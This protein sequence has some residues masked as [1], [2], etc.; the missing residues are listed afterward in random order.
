M[1]KILNSN[2][3]QNKVCLVIGTRPGIVMFSPIIRALKKIKFNFFI[4]HAGQH[5]S[6]NMDKKF[7]EDLELPE[8]EY[9]LDEVKNCKF[10]GEQ[11]ARMLEGI[12]KILLKE[13]PKIV[14]VGGDA[15][16]NLAGALAARKLH[17]KVG[18]VEAGERS[19]DWRM[20]EEHNRRMIDHISEYLFVT[21]EKR[22]QN[23]L[24]ESVLGKIF[25]TGNPIVDAA[26]QN[27]EI[28]KEKS[29]ILKQWNL[30]EKDYFILT[31]HR[32]ENVDSKENLKNIILGM[33]NVCEKFRKKVIFLAHPRTQKRIEQFALTNLVNSIHNFIVKDAV[34]YLDFIN[35][36]SHALLVFTDSGGVQQEACIFKI[37]C[38][39][40]RK[41]TEWVETIKLGVN[42]L[43][44]TDPNKIV[45][46][47]QRM[48][49]FK[50]NWEEPFGDGKAVERIVDIINKEV[51]KKD[52]FNNKSHRNNR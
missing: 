9:K 51:I 34:G 45:N 7:F 41:N 43:A 20:P 40:L 6:Y 39:T 19:Y 50:G 44:G 24:K 30:K 8:P 12:E 17:I 29:D 25:I 38:V 33:K 31:T 21:N 3:L 26:Y 36:L 49:S 11:T 28:A 46:C 23:L 1:L 14:L 18:H 37:P 15:N 47:A 48:L 2:E 5:Y 27:R 22:K 52:G 42:I 10:H 35:L 16:C 13:K 4:I 32:E